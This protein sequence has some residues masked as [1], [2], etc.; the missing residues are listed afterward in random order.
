MECRVLWDTEAAAYIR[1]RS[2]RYPGALNIEPAWT[3]EVLA[4]PDM[5]AAEPDPK[6]RIRAGRF[7]GYSV[8]AAAVL[9]LV[10]WR[11]E[12]GELH[13]INAWKTRRA[14]LRRYEEDRDDGS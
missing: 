4:D 2:D 6:S 13:G 11:D 1:A 3:E 12:D 8:S 7:I 9:T 5:L 14:E 10:A